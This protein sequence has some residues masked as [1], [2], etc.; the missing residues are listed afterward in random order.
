MSNRIS[1]ADIDAILREFSEQQEQETRAA[2]SAPSRRR[3]SAA[4]AAQERSPR[5]ESRPEP[6]TERSKERAP[7]PA[8]RR[9]ARQAPER[10]KERD[11]RS[12]PQPPREATPVRPAFSF[13]YLI[14]IVLSI[15]ALV[16]A[17][18]NVHPGTGTNTGS[19]TE[20]RL[21]LVGKLDVFMNNS[22]SDALENVAYIKKIYTIPESDLVAPK[23]DQSK[24]GSTTDPA[25]V[26]AV[27]DSAAELLEGQELIWN[28]DIVLMEGSEIE[29]YCDET[30]LVIA[31]KEAINNSAC[32]FVEVKIAHG[33]QLRRALS[34]NTY[35]SS[36]YMYPTQMAQNANAVVAIN[37]D[38]YGH[39]SCGITVY[40]RQLYRFNP[41]SLESCFF[42][43][44]G[45]MI[46]THVGELNTEDDVK[47]FVQDNDITFSISFGPILVENGEKKTT[48]TYLVGEVDIQYSRAA[49]GQVDKLH[50]LLMSI[51]EEGVYKNRVTI[52]QA[53]DL[54]YAK[55]VPNAYALDGGQTATIVMNGETFNRPDWG[56][57]RI[58]TDIIYFATA[59]PGE[60][61]SS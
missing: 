58:M 45:D 3:E 43:A 7:Q 49:I 15:L 13:G 41:R 51:N 27:V 32:S 23:P 38:F 22:A 39:R 54:I 61:A 53:A 4:P 52:N 48:N 30:I 8:P 31:W 1:D 10:P 12:R 60:E 33:S 11:A 24:F 40:Q 21:D 2:E 16:W 17:L 6:R 46:F 56:N 34:D 20:N 50:Y 18:V 29:Y 19:T 5:R 14:L 26:Q 57:E 47:R 9:E 28:P 59:I 25:V 44:S 37:G 36:V 35:G 55:G 42:T